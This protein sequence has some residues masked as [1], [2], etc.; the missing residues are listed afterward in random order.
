MVGMLLDSLY[1][2]NRAQVFEFLNG[3]YTRFLKKLLS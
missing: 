1:S 2:T 3:V